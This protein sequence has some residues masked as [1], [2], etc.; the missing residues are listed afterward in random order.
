ME[1]TATDFYVNLLGLAVPRVHDLNL[2]E[3]GLPQVDLF[4]LDSHFRVDEVWDAVRPINLIHSFAKLLAKEDPWIG[5]LH[6]A[7]I[8]PAVLA[9]VKPKFRKRRSILQGCQGNAWVRDIPGVLS[10]DVVVQYPNLWAFVET[11]PQRGGDDNLKPK[12]TPGGIF[13]SRSAYHALFHGAT[14]LPGAGNVW[15]SYA[16][17]VFK[18]HAWLALCRRCWT[19]DRLA[20]HGMPSHVAYLL[21]NV[22]DDTLD[23]LSLLCAYALPVWSAAD[24]NLPLPNQ[25]LDVWWPTA[26][27]V[28][29][30]AHRKDTNSLIMMVI[31]SLWL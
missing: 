11:I 17:V 4:G 9:I 3:L 22:E 5:G 19:T 2:A 20:C 7:A 23:H 13:S 1:D 31:R 29:P 30:M 27:D 6:V 24:L 26:V 28:M 18:F 16:P 21:F 15:H 12:W 10:V 8:A 25:G 14:T